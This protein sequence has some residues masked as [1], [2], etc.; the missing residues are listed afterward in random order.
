[1][2]TSM[3]GGRSW[4]TKKEISLSVWR[5]MRVKFFYRVLEASRIRRNRIWTFT[6]AV[7]K[8]SSRMNLSISLFD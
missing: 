5:S 6:I 7:G 8:G 2:M 3:L 1:M 4:T